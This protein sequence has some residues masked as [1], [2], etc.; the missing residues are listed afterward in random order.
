LFDGR[1][2]ANSALGQ[3]TIGSLHGFDHAGTSNNEFYGNIFELSDPLGSPTA[4]FF[5]RDDACLIDSLETGVPREL[6]T[7]LSIHNN[8]F[9]LGSLERVL[10]VK[11]AEQRAG[12]DF[13]NNEIYKTVEASIAS[14]KNLGDNTALKTYTE[15]MADFEGDATGTTL[16]TD[17]Y[18]RPGDFYPDPPSY[19]PEDP[20]EEP[21]EPGEPEDPP[22]E[23]PP[24]VVPPD[25]PPP[26]P[27]PP[28]EVGIAEVVMAQKTDKALDITIP[29]DKTTVVY[30][31]PVSRSAGQKLLLEFKRDPEY[32]SGAVVVSTQDQILLGI[33][34]AKFVYMNGFF[35]LEN[36]YGR[37]WVLIGTD[38]DD[39]A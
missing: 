38:Y 28:H 32:R 18:E 25:P 2:S 19:E 12:I 29:L 20:P 17:P 22:E 10:A 30:L 36:I 6:H 33:G 8:L 9:A 26:P 35:L 16:V 21:E 39:P 14:F 15:F 37:R 3:V 5:V 27:P 7:G 34:K 31:P 1:R 24:I 13:T 11:W 4:A 23:P